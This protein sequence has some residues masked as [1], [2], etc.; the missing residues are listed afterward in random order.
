MIGVLLS[1]GVDSACLMGIAKDR[2]LDFCAIYINWHQPSYFFEDIAS[3]NISDHYGVKRHSLWF[4][5]SELNKP[6]R[7]GVGTSG[8]R[9]VRGRNMLFLTMAATVPNIT[10]LWYGACKDDW[11]DYADCTPEFVTKANAAMEVYGIK[12][13]APLLMMDKRAIGEVAR[14][15]QVP[16]HL[17]WSC[18]EPRQGQQCGTCNSCVSNK[19]GYKNK[20]ASSAKDVAG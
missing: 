7:T 4:P 2:G 17:A 19:T 9:F 14:D 1:G 3:E 13:T 11:Q 20:Y 18:Y 15:L 10:E 8:P 6:M 12:V 16:V 5:T